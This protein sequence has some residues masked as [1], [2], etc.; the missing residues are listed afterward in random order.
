MRK[1]LL[2]TAVGNPLAL[3]ELP[4]SLG[5]EALDVSVDVARLPITERLERAF[6]GRVSELPPTT[7][8]T[9]LVAALDECGGLRAVLDAAALIAGRAVSVD[10]LTPAE[11]ARL[12]FVEDN[13]LRFRDPLVRAA[14]SQGARAAAKQAA[15]A[16]LAKAHAADPDRS[17]WHRA[18]AP[19]GEE[20][21]VAADL[22]VAADRAIRRGAPQAAAAALK[23]AAQPTADA[24]RGILLLR[25][26]EM[27]FELGRPDLST[28]LLAEAN[29]LELGQQQRARLSFLVE[30][31]EDGSW[32]GAT[33]VASPVEIANQ[34]TLAGEPERALKTLLVIALSCWWGN[35]DEQT[36][37]AVVAAAERLPCPEQHPALIAILACADPV[38]RGALVIDRISRMT[39]DTA[40]PAGMCLVGSAA[41]A[42]W[43]HDLSLAF[44][45]TAVDGLPAR[46]TSSRQLTS[47][48]SERPVIVP[49]RTHSADTAGQRLIP[50]GGDPV[51]RRW[52]RAGGRGGFFAG[53]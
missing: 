51:G 10:D 6:S 49:E 5:V 47:G 24:G 39:P 32:S 52:G 11:E 27:A 4:R 26:A 2:E 18:A 53:E 30:M 12:V 41:T 19:A 38:G 9:L 3:V 35:P 22:E 48:R 13:D 20:E 28:R 42:V 45:E 43:T 37:A 17:L 14:I 1:R 25:A 29:P 34:M 44:L 31:L 50:A 36:R 16:A 23:R 40:D 46:K 7:R 33:K 8:T 21:H 15:H